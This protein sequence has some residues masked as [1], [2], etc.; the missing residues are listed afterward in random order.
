MRRLIM[1]LIA[2]GLLALPAVAAAQEAA[3]TAAATTSTIVHPG[4]VNTF[5]EGLGVFKMMIKAFGDKNW[6]LGAALILTLLVTICRFFS[7]VRKIPKQ[8]VPWIAAALA[9]ATSVAVG[10]QAGLGAWAITTT[11][12]TVGL[13][14]VGGWETLGKL[15]RG[16]LRKLLPGLAAKLFGDTAPPAPPLPPADGPKT[17]P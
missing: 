9:M 15:L 10:L 3:A 5:A 6:A 16:V 8:W 13:T 1:L 2:V 7:V 14:A 12:I 11:G 4:D 17:E